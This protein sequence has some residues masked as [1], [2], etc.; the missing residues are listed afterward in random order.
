VAKEFV[1]G[2]VPSWRKTRRTVLAMGALGLVRRRRL[3]LCGIARGMDSTCRIIHPELPAGLRD[4][5]ALSRA[6]KQA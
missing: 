3:T 4:I 6:A 2:L 1:T 5:A